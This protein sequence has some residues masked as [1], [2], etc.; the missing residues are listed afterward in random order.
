MKI[1]IEIPSE[2]ETHFEQDRF[3][4]S[5]H[6]LSA[7]AHLLAGNYE[8]EVLTMLIKAFKD[9]SVIKV[10]EDAISR[11]YMLRALNGYGKDWQ[12]DC[13]IAE[14]IRNAPSVVP[15]RAEGKWVKQGLSP[16]EGVQRCSLCG[17]VYNITEDFNYCPNCG[18]KMKGKER[19]KE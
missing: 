16:Y 11:E 15:S 8:Q 5:L 17:N 18:M 12:E 14:I 6:R 10:S 9:C 1:V 3:E 7:D 13:E 4:D 2:F 19:I